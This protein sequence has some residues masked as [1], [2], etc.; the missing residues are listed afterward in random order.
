MNDTAT[1]ETAAP[2]VEETKRPKI[3]TREYDFE[4]AQVSSVGATV[5]FT[6]A[7][8][9]KTELTFDPG[10]LPEEMRARALL[11]GLGTRIRNA[12]ASCKGDV[13]KAL[14]TAREEFEQLKRGNWVERVGGDDSIAPSTKLLAECLAEVTG[15]PAD[16]CMVAIGK[17]DKKQRAALRRDPR[18]NEKYEAKK[19][20]KAPKEVD[21]T[22]LLNA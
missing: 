14:E 21:L 2:E 12:Y 22:A 1:P 8:T 15:K 5:S 16:A 3:A 17:L 7:D 13:A 9:A 11:F 20:K 4:N 18:I 6:F 10:E 19:P